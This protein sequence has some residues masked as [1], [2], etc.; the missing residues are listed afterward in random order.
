MR[1]WLKTALFVSAFSPSLMSIAGSRLI[2]EG[3]NWPAVYYGFAGFFGILCTFYIIDALKWYGEEFPFTAKKIESNDA[4]MLAFVGT[5]FI[6]FAAKAADITPKLTLLLLGLAAVVLWFSSSIPTSPLL[7]MFGFRFYKIE[8]AHGVV[9][10][11][12]TTREILDPSKVKSVK[13]I[14]S[15]MLLEVF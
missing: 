4:I 14:S 13:Q 12:I 2:S 11:I 15:S 6:P 10:T 7:R 1:N 9:Y 8:S 3:F 5:Y